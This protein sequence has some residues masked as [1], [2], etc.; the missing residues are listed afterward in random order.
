[1]CGSLKFNERVITL[2][3]PFKPDG[4]VL[5]QEDNMKLS[6]FRTNKE[7]YWDGWAK[8]ESLTEKWLCK[9]NWVSAEILATSFNERGNDYEIP[10]GYSIRAI[11]LE[12]PHRVVI[13]IVTREAEG[14]EKRVHDR[15][16][17]TLPRRL[18]IND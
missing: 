13:K 9:E 6:A 3:T 14:K 8:K 4:K 1:M 18:T 17:L 5:I 15:F 11:A 10:C 16:A 12:L 7:I 2:R